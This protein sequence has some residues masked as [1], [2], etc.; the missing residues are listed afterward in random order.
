MIDWYTNIQKTVLQQKQTSKTISFG[1]R[2]IQQ[3]EYFVS[4]ADANNVWEPGST[5]QTGLK[6]IEVL[7][8]PKKKNFASPLL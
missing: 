4:A 6:K 2:K 5:T 7:D 1:G 3:G 8:C